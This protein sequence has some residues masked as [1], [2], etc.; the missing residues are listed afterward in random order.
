MKENE[1]ELPQYYVTAAHTAIIPPAEWDEVAKELSR[2]KYSAKGRFT[3]NA[4]SGKL[5]CGEAYGPKV[6]HSNDK[7]RRVIWQ[8]NAKFRDKSKKCSTPHLAEEQIREAYTKALSLL[9]VDKEQFAED[10]G[11]L[12]TVLA[13]TAELEKHIGEIQ[14]EIDT[15]AVLIRQCVEGSAAHAFSGF[16]REITQLPEINIIFSE[17]RFN[18]TVDHITVHNDGRL[19]FSFFVGRDITVE[20]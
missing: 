18:K 6:W 3:G 11:L 8:C 16:M 4:F 5:I 13:D 1:G 12:K 20:T 7:Y 10:A 9:I 19:V 15:V 2:R 17:N 14:R